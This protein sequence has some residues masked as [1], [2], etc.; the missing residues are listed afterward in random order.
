[1]NNVAVV[2]DNVDTV[3]VADDD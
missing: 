3:T 2:V 1:M